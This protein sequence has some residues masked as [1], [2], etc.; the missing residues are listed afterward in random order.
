MEVGICLFGLLTLCV[1]DVNLILQMLKS[2]FSK[3]HLF[4]RL[5]LLPCL[6]LCECLTL[7]Q[8]LGES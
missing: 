2:V 7:S 6:F 3:A 4:A 8:H 5:S 1:G